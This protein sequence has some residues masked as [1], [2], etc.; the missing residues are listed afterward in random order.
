M[1]FT[2]QQSLHDKNRNDGPRFFSDF[3]GFGWYWLIFY[4]T[5]E[6]NDV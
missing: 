1:N 5:L 6:R 4:G 2:K 3:L